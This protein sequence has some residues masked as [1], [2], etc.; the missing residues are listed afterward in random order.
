MKCQTIC[1]ASCAATRRKR[2]RVASGRRVIH[3]RT[4]DEVEKIRR[5]AQVVARTLVLLRD[6]VKPGLT[7]GELDRAAEQYI[8]SQGA[9]PTFIGY[10][11]Y[12]NALCTSVNEEVVHGIPGPRVLH[13][14]DIVGIDCG[15]T[16]NGYVGDSAISCAV[17]STDAESERLMRVTRESLDKAIAVAVPGNRIGDISHAVQAHCEANGFGVVRALV[18]HGIGRE[19]HEEPAVPN[20]GRPG[21]G[22]KLVAG[23]VLAIEP[24]VTIGTWDVVTLDDGWTVVTN[25]GKRSAHFE[26]TV[27]IT[28]DG[29][30]VL[31]VA[32]EVARA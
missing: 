11:G 17:G 13:E 24:M 21:S 4:A 6:M 19:M 30:E 8:R 23:M 5:A 28:A 32:E 22:P 29:P 20:Y 15:A 25:D 26:H 14:G 9:I 10:R 2:F 1:C 31:S 18:G 3:I 16:L 12:R 7:T 27:A